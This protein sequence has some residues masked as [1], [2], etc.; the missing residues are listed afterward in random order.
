MSADRRWP[1]ARRDVLLIAAAALAV[2]GPASAA[3]AR[4]RGIATDSCQG[5]HGSEASSMVTLTADK[6]T[7]NPGDMVTFTLTIKWASLK[8]GGAFIFSDGIGTLRAISG[9]GLAINGTALM[10]SAPKAGSGQVTFRF[11]WQA[12]NTPGGVSFH[13]AALAANGNNTTSGDAPGSG[14]FLWAFGCTARTLYRDSDN[15]GYGAAAFGTL[16]GC[17]DAA[18]PVGYSAREGDCDEN[19]ERVNPGA[20][21][22]CNL[23]DD[24]CDGQID[25]NAPPTMLW[26]DG[27]GDGYYKFQTGTPKMGC[28]SVPGYAARSGD[29]VDTDPQVNPGVAEICNL[30]DDNCDGRIDE[31][32]RPTCGVGSCRR[33]S[34]TCD[35]VA[36]VPGVPE[37]ETCNLL[38]DDCDGE[39][40]EDTCGAEM[41]CLLAACVPADGSGGG[42][43]AGVVP[44]DAGGAGSGGGSAS[45]TGGAGTG[46]PGTGGKGS[47][48]AGAG[49]CTLAGRA[50]VG[51]AALWALLAVIGLGA[52]RRGRRHPTPRPR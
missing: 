52:G 8:A 24:N 39:I 47:P 38:D 35:L 19:D 16:L 50:G 9:E 41:V 40:D 6:A 18:P 32:M 37:M 1:R 20:A 49:G 27:D 17:P 28:G 22:I 14:Q 3:E 42:P 25:E 15:D 44:T 13:V 46:S 45:G 48:Q 51:A 31:R 23:K 7:F 12:P 34:P 10:H 21:E 4:S 30:K 43:D 11:G 2:L 5:C 33:N 29:C 26:P 36:C